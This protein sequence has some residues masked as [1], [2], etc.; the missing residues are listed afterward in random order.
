MALV[1]DIRAIEREA[2]ERIGQA[3]SLDSLRELSVQYLGKKGQLTAVLKALGSLPIDER[4]AVGAEANRVRTLLEQSI[5]ETTSRLAIAAGP[6]VDPTLPGIGQYIG[7]VHIINQVMGEICDIFHGMGFEIARGPHIE[8]DYY[9]FEALNFAP[10]HPARD[11]HD[12]FFVEGG[13]LLRTHTTPVQARELER[14]TPPMKIL[15]PGRT[16]RHEDVSTRSHISFHQVDGF[17]VDK[18]V[19]VA[20]LKGTLNAFCKAFFGADVKLR[21]RPSFFPF[22]EPS[23]EV[24]I[25]CFLCH[26]KGCQLCKFAGWL[27]ILGSGMIHPNVLRMAGHDPEIYSGFAFG[28]GVERPAILKYRINDIR[29]FFNNNLRFLRQFV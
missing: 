6:S 18:G 17:L 15:M 24:D 21:F 29:L 12:T 8:T 10:D 22:T 4:K 3:G 11:E 19:S 28:M 9:N 27:E 14:R 20:D 26:G 13:R 16:F 25:S 1:D 7:A 5:E 2:L 23:A